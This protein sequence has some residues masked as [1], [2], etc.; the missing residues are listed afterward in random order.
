MNARSSRSH[1]CFIVTVKQSNMKTFSSQ[2]GQLYLVDLAGSERTFKTGAK[3]KLLDEANM[4]N[5][6]LTNLGK[7]INHL[8]D[9]KSTHI[10]YR[11]SKLTRILQESLG[12]NARTSLIITCS[13]AKYN[14]DETLSTLRFGARAKRIKNKP[15]V[16]KELTIQ[17][18]QALYEEE[19]KKNEHKTRRIR[20]LEKLLV[21]MGAQLPKDT[22]GAAQNDDLESK[23]QDLEEEKQMD[24][25]DKLLKQAMATVQE[26]IDAQPK[27]ETLEQEV[28]TEVEY[29]TSTEIIKEVEKRVEVPIE[30]PVEVIKEVIREV[31]I[32][33]DG[34]KIDNTEIT[35]DETGSF[36]IFDSV[37]SP[38]DPDSA[39]QLTFEFLQRTKVSQIQILLA[40]VKRHVNQMDEAFI[41]IDYIKKLYAE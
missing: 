12:G 2:T 40:E 27:P 23:E 39:D 28:Q 24:I 22:F 11:D 41:K 35:K 3:G 37:T 7:V 13:P 4:I 1:T 30:V 34:D 26:Q 19:K 18:I 17:E 15:K 20:Q 16:N 6:S 38:D 5:K 21:E 29:P 25:S 31:H 9:G 14:L 36:K 8:T 10:P 32:K 33:E